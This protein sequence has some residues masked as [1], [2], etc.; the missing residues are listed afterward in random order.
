MPLDNREQ[1]KLELVNF[2]CF[3]DQQFNLSSPTVITG[4]NGVGKT[5]ILEALYYLS[6]AK[7]YRTKSD[8]ELVSWN[9]TVTRLVLTGRDFK[10]ERALSLSPQLVKRVKKNDV[11]VSPLESLGYL[12]VVV[13]SPEQLNIF[14]G[15]PSLRR[16][17]LDVILTSTDQTY[18][19]ALL[20]YQHALKQR[21]SLL[22]QAK[23]LSD[24]LFEPWE[25]ILAT[26]GTEITTKRNVLVEFIGQLINEQYQELLVNRLAREVDVSYLVSCR[27]EKLKQT[28]AQKRFSDQRSGGTSV[29]PHR[30]DLIFK[31]DNY[32]LAQAASRGEQRSFLWA[33]KLAELEFVNTKD[34]DCRLLL[35]LDDMFSELDQVRSQ[36]LNELVVNYPAIITATDADKLLDQNINQISLSPNVTRAN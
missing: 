3:K 27:S 19:Q 11:V 22:W 31:I 29:G 25:E 30:D 7:S 14:T 26:Y 28:L 16:R 33:L 24:Q 34:K 8:R 12:R 6:I 32:P 18:G 1:L 17:F 23:D 2:R 20:A 36:K 4:P 21:N 5:S 15:S 9:E 13:F 10:L 35:L